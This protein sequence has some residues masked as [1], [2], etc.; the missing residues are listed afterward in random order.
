MWA[1]PISAPAPQWLLHAPF[2]FKEPYAVK[3]ARGVRKRVFK[4]SDPQQTA[5]T[6]PYAA[7]VPGTT[8]PPAV[9]RVVLIAVLV[10]IRDPENLVLFC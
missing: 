7:R 4:S 3:I 5:G 1:S 10:V 6:T 9:K 8:R 2:V